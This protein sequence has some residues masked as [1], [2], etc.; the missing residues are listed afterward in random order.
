MCPNYNLSKCGDSREGKDG[1]RAQQVNVTT[2]ESGMSTG[3]DEASTN[4][5]GAVA[6]HTEFLSLGRHVQEALK[7]P[8]T[9][10]W[11][12]LSAVVARN[13]SVLCTITDTVGALNFSFFQLTLMTMDWD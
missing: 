5:P 3:A 7:D 8:N 12:V 6:A 1:R 4:S 2:G 10:G 13:E 9:L 11:I